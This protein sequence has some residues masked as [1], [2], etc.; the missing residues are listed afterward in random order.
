MGPMNRVIALLLLPAALLASGCASKA[1]LEAGY[2]A[3]LQHWRG[4]SR[5]DLEAAWGKP[6]LVALGADGLVLTWVVRNDSL[7]DRP[8]N[9]GAG[10]VV[11]SHP[12][13]SN[14][15]TVGTVVP[16][17]MASASVPITCTTHFSMKDDRVV[18]W[19]FEGLGCGAPF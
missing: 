15:P 3:S 2:D 5:A 11:V 13:G 4:A 12:M 1:S 7:Q 6:T 8:G 16:G 14:G 10:T 18:S 17:A 19:K 9:N